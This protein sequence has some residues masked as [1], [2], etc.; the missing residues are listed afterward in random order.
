[1][2]L[3]TD[4]LTWTLV[5]LAAALFL[6]IRRWQRG[7]GVGLLLA[8]V[9]SFGAIHWLATAMYLLPWYQ[10]VDPSLVTEGMRQ[11]A[12][13]MLALTVGVELMSWIL[14]RRAQQQ[15]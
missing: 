4:L 12:L 3:N 14:N 11:S 8:Y 13:G 1:M 7:V 10:H 15:A 5:W 6:L 9:V 2:T